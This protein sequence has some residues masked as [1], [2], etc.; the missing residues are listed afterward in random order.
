[1]HHHHSFDLQP[2]LVGQK[3]SL[4][5]LHQQHYEELYQVASDRLI[6]EQHP[7]PNRFERIFFQEGFF[8]GAL[9]SG[10]ALIVID[11]NSN[12]TIGSTRYYDWNPTL[13]E[14]AIGFTFLA[15]DYWGGKTN[16]EIKSLMLRH[17]F[18]WAKVV[19]FHVGLNNTRSRKAVEKIGGVFSHIDTS[20]IQGGIERQRAFY[21][22]DSPRR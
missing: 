21:R 6:W 10:G 17:A 4:L 9:S 15:R 1:M 18:R 16:S 22:I 13:K 20:K 7:E 8:S 2:T 11:N 19:W 14:V 12:K 3:I 5:P